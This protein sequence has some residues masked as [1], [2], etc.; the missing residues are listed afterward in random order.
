[1]KLSTQLTIVI[2]TSILGILGLVVGLAVL[3]D[4]SDGA[5]IGM[6][7]AFGAVIVNTVISVRNQAK[8]AEVLQGQSEVLQGQD[9]KLDRVVHQTNG[10]SD[11]ERQDIAERAAAS[12]VRQ[13]RG[14]S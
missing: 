4:W 12:V 6:V 1:M 8:T 14:D 11:A 5:I 10:L 3:A 13:F 2:C 7:T 9:D